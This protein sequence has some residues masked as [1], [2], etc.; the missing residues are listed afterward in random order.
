MSVNKRILF[1]DNYE[2]SINDDIIEEEPDVN[3]FLFSSE[4]VKFSSINNTFD[5]AN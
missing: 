2:G 5:Y 4:I 3:A 1:G